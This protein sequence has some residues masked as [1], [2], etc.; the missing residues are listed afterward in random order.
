V[1][2]VHRLHLNGAS[3]IGLRVIKFFFDYYQIPE[4]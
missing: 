4:L 3:H 2:F 1:R